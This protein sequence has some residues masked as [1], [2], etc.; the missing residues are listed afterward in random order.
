[1]R[2]SCAGEEGRGGGC[3]CEERVYRA[4]GERRKV[5]WA[6]GRPSGAAGRGPAR[7]EDLS[8]RCSSRRC[9]RREGAHHH[10]GVLRGRGRG[11]AGAPRRSGS[12]SAAAMPRPRSSQSERSADTYLLAEPEADAVRGRE[13]QW[14]APRGEGRGKGTD[15]SECL[16]NLSAHVLTQN[17]CCASGER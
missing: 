6:A 1:V 9:T 16:R 10:L 17:S 3:A 5:R 12:G 7:E 11:S 4:E 13:G 15:R 14:G 2:A 8:Q